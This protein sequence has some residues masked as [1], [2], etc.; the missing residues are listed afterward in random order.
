M[1]WSGVK[2]VKVNV[3]RMMNQKNPAPANSF[4]SDELFQT[5]MKIMTMNDILV[6]A[7]PMAMGKFQ[8]PMWM[9]AAQTVRSMRHAS[10][11]PLMT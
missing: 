7:M 11:Q 4:A 1:K 5:F 6:M 2:S 10:I 9:L 3:M 8:R